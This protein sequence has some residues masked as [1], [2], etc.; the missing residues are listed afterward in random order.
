MIT[1]EEENQLLDR[2]LAGD[3]QA[4]ARL[5]DKHKSFA[6]TIAFKVL[7]NRAEAE[8]AAQDAFIKA[9][10]YLKNFNRQARFSTWLYRIT[11]N[12]AISYKRKHKP[13][14]Q[15]VE[16]T[17]ITDN[18]LVES[19]L[20]QH[21]KLQFVHKAMQALNEADRLA[22]QLFYLNEFSLEEVATITAQNVNTVKVRVHRARQRLAD[23]LKR[24]LKQEAITL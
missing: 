8:E 17:V 6:F 5:V 16:Q 12:T 1:S 9:F 4:Y 19:E 2:I 13:V 11:F 14:F 3:K 15:S 7:D 24:I 22:L 21:D 23:E 10:H 20:E 18:N